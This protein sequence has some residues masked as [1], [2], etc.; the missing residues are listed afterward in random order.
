LFSVRCR[1]VEGAVE[2]HV[3]PRKQVFAL[4]VS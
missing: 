2:M 4:V 3:L 1:E